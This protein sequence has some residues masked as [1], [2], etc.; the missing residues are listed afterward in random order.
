[1]LKKKK[2]SYWVAA[3]FAV[4]TVVFFQNCSQVAFQT[5]M[6]SFTKTDV[7]DTTVDQGD[8]DGNNGGSGDN[9]NSPGG[10]SDS[11]PGYSETCDNYSAV[12]FA[13][14]DEC[15]KDGEWHLVPP[16]NTEEIERHMYAGADV[17]VIIPQQSL[18]LKGKNLGIQMSGNEECQQFYRSQAGSR[19][20]YCLTTIRFG[21]ELLGETSHGSA[22]YGTDGS[23]FCNGMRN[24][25]ANGCTVDPMTFKWYFRY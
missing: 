24:P 6:A 15:Q 25:G 10:G 7:L 9:G 23:I 1:M 21:G 12:G 22:R 13:S 14:K 17:K 20:F 8:N 2:I 16:T 11:E 19:P 18:F 4:S 3:L 5:E